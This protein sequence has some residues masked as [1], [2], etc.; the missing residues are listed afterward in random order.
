MKKVFLSLS[1]MLTVALS[2]TFAAN[3]PITGEEARETFK[4]EFAGAESVIWKQSGDYLKA[5]FIFHGYNTEAYFNQ[6]G[7]L[8]G[9]VRAIHYNQLPLTVITTIN[10]KFTDA[11]VLDVYEISNANGTMYRLTFNADNKKYRVKSD[12]GG[13]IM[14]KE[15]L[16]N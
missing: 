13:N 8:E 11:D 15:K 10:K 16:K 3:N 2:T 12:G 4:K 6:E 14:E 9:T 7:E 5:N 1:F